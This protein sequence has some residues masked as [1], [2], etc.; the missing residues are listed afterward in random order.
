VLAALS[1]L[2]SCELLRVRIRHS[3]AAVAVA[4][5]AGDAALDLSAEH[6]ARRWASAHL[7]GDP[8]LG[9][10][11]SAGKP[12]LGHRRVHG[13]LVGL[14][15]R[16]APATVWNMLYKAGLD[17]APRLISR[18]RQL[19]RVVAEYEDHYNAPYPHRALGQQPPILDVSHGD[20]R[21]QGA[22]RE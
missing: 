12:D 5:A 4:S 15:Y 9:G 7:C 16:L 18:E 22:V 17:P 19:V 21:L 8:R 2:L 1:G 11:V 20:A 10:S 3:G 6:P 13:E 14:G